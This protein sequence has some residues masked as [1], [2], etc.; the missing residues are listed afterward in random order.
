MWKPL[1]T[2]LLAVSMGA[3]ALFGPAF[4]SAS[5]LHQP[6]GKAKCTRTAYANSC[7][8]TI[9]AKGK[10]SIP[11]PGT[12]AKLIGTG[13]KATAGTRI[14]LAKVAAPK[15]SKGGVGMKVNAT[16]KFNPLRLSKGTLWRY[17]PSNNSLSRVKKV[18]HTG[19]YQVTGA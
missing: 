18:K 8:I 16:G 15:P 12:S 9:P 11:V 14:T 19:I 17:K 4:A 1:A 6:E 5:P 13:S 3:S 7:G 10:F 2:A